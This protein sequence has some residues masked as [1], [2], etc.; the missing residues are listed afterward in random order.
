MRSL[1][2]TEVCLIS[3]C[4]VL[5]ACSNTPDLKHSTR[6]GKIFD[7]KVGEQIAPD[8]MQVRLGD[9]V[10]WINSRSEPINI[11]FVDNLKDRLSCQDGFITGGWFKGMFSENAT[12]PRITT[13]QPNNHAS[14]CFASSGTY[15]YNTRMDSVVPGGEKNLKG[16]IVVE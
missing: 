5:A 8:Q 1:I 4:L 14:L 7:I 10:R 15:T 3:M 13:L 6:T 9:E 12:V 2:P 11:V 16:S